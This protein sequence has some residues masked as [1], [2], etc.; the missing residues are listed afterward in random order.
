MQQQIAWA[1]S[2]LF[3]VSF[4]Q[5]ATVLWLLIYWQTHVSTGWWACLRGCFASA[6]VQPRCANDLTTD[7]KLATVSHRQRFS[8]RSLLIDLLIHL[9]LSWSPASRGGR[10]I[11]WSALRSTN[12]VSR[13]LCS[14]TLLPPAV[15]NEN[16]VCC[17]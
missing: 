16:N 13:H 5:T 7:T 9:A 17:K 10:N 4:V 6:T 1:R 12:V 14:C 11:P 15:M 3:D 8:V 2:C